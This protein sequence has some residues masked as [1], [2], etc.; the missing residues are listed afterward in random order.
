VFYDEYIRLIIIVQPQPDDHDSP[1]KEAIDH[2]FPELLSFYF[3]EAFK[4][5][6]WT[7]SIRFLDE[8][9]RSILPQAEHGK[10]I[11]DK[12]IEVHL[13]DGTETWFYIHLEVQASRDSELPKRMFISNYRIYDKYGKLVASFAIL[14]DRNRHWRPASYSYEIA[15]TKHSL[16]FSTVKLIDYESRMEEL[17]ASD[18]AFALI[19]AAH[20]LTQQ[21]RDKHQ[22]RFDAKLRLFR[23]LYERKWSRERI[24][25]LV[26]VMDWFLELPKELRQQLKHELYQIEE[27]YNMPYITSFERDAKEEGIAIGE[28]RGIEKGK[29]EGLEEGLLRG[30]LEVAER[31]VANGMSK[32]EAALLAGV[33]VE[34]L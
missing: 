21:T 26:R 27:G 30:R 8:E 15:G 19:T 5:I 7:K 14:A 3:P 29:A 31:L 34:M 11:V 18:N 28:E 17:L 1:W 9:L 23:L 32:Q 33:D 2:F 6:D 12:L 24:V 10:R 16:A 13:L 4:I 25:E 22:Q 20:L